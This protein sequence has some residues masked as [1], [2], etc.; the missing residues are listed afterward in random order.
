MLYSKILLISIVVL[1]YQCDYNTKLS[2]RPKRRELGNQLYLANNL[3]AKPPSPREVARLVV[4]EG[5][6]NDIWCC[7]LPQSAS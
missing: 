5:V 7:F 6:Y 2:S 4:T 3:K 1:E